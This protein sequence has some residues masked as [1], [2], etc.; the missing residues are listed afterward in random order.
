MSDDDS[1]RP[2]SIRR[3]AARRLLGTASNL[4]TRARLQ[5]E[6]L[7]LRPAPVADVLLMDS[8]QAAYEQLHRRF[9]ERA[10]RGD[11]G[12]DSALEALDA[13]WE[14][15]RQLRGGAPAILLTLS[16]PHETVQD[17]RSRFYLEST[18]L[19]EDAIRAVFATDMGQLAV[20]PE[21]MA[22]LVR[23]VLEG[24]VVELAQ[25]RT[26]ADVAKVDQAYAD[27]RSLF[28]RFV[29]GDA[30]APLAELSLEPIPLPW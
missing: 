2:A 20:P 6:A 13:M 24:L 15:V 22:V 7:D 29:L 3:R 28:A 19:L 12:L 14:I 11:G 27:L 9:V 16:N 17:R 25:A 23:V 4:V 10:G 30:S 21:R 5:A 8:Q 26:A 18:R 1:D